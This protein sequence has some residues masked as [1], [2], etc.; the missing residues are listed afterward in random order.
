MSCVVDGFVIFAIG[1]K[2]SRIFVEFRGNMEW[3]SKIAFGFG[4]GKA[5]PE[6]DLECEIACFQQEG[7]LDPLMIFREDQALLET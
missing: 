4:C 7:G 5:S 2:G 6:D 3:S 1:N